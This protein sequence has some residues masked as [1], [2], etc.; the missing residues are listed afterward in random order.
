MTNAD[1]RSTAHTQPGSPSSRPR[2]RQHRVAKLGDEGRGRLMWIAGVTT[3]GL[4]MW[5]VCRLTADQQVSTLP[6]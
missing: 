2:P 6:G 4:V 3:A 5:V 1:A